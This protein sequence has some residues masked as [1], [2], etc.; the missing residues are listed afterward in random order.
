MLTLVN[1][2]TVLKTVAQN[3][4]KGALT[5]STTETALSPCQIWTAGSSRGFTSE[6]ISKISTHVLAMETGTYTFTG[7]ETISWNSDTYKVVGYPDDVANQGEIT[8]I[9]LERISD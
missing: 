9:G 7:D 6:L 1:A 5:I 4:G 8:I 2:V 3:N